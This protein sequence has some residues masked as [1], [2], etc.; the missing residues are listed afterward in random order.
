M[1]PR[2]ARPAGERCASSLASRIPTYSR[3]S[4]LT[5]MP[6]RRSPKPPDGHPS[7][8]HPIGDR[9]TRRGSLA[10]TSYRLFRLRR[11]AV[12]FSASV[13]LSSASSSRLPGSSIRLAS[14]FGS[15]ETGGD[16]EGGIG[17]TVAI[18]AIFLLA[19]KCR[20]GWRPYAPGWHRARAV[21]DRCPPRR[22]VRKGWWNCARCAAT[23]GELPPPAAFREPAASSCRSRP[24]NQNCSASTS[25]KALLTC[26][27]RRIENP[28][29]SP[30]DD[31][32]SPTAGFI[33]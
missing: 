4:S 12:V 25:R 2:P 33:S 20:A 27:P 11:G 19:R 9:S 29:Q 3:R 14:M 28:S 15:G 10:L 31:R 21:R 1:T 30:N 26:A 24:A 23:G 7:G 8:R 5:R 13:D 22:S 16:A 6:K 18:V 32:A 17:D